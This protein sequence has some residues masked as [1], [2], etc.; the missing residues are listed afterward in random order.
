MPGNLTT[1]DEWPAVVG[2]RLVPAFPSNAGK[3]ALPDQMRAEI[4]IRPAVPRD[5]ESIAALMREGV[6]EAVRRITIMCSPHLGRFVADELAGGT[7]YEYVVGTLE[8]QVVGMG[9]WRHADR[10]LQLDHLFVA[11]K[12]RGRGLGTALVLD[13]LRRIRR[14]EEQQ[15]RL[16]VF[17]DNP[18]ALAWYRVW[19]MHR[20]EE[21]AWIEMSLP[22][23]RRQTTRATIAGWA[24]AQARQLR[25]GFSR[26][27]LAT[28]TGTHLIGRLGTRLFRYGSFGILDDHVALSEL[29]RLDPERQLLCVSPAT[30]V[31]SAARRAGVMVAQSERLIVPCDTLIKRLESSSAQ[32]R[33]LL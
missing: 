4:L 15:L 8:G 22:N 6:S 10:V 24:E 17:L 26:F 12:A 3:L 19:K 7:T 33:Y 14:A 31:P 25:Y 32:C 16:D 9:C 2:P 11:P 18:R 21:I 23:L 13:G 5:G 29:A 30:E 20:E 27:T 28:G 1:H